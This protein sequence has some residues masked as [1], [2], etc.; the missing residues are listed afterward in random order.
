MEIQARIVGEVIRRLLQLPCKILIKIVPLRLRDL[1]ERELPCPAPF[2]DLL[3]A[4]N[5]LRHCAKKLG[6]DQEMNLIF[7]G[8]TIENAGAVFPNASDQITRDTDIERAVTPAR[9]DINARPLRRLR[10]SG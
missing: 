5:H 1:D 6:M 7:L 3:L 4:Q 2:L 8:E 10:Y 9:Q